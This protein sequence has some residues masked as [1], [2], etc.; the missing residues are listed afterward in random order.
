MKKTFLLFSLVL[1]VT[2]LLSKTTG[3]WEKAINAKLDQSKP[4]EAQEILKEWKLNKGESD[5][6]YWVAGGNIWIAM[7][8]EVPAVVTN[9]PLGTYKLGKGDDQAIPIQDQKTGKTVGQITDGPPQIDRPKMLKAIDCLNHGVQVAPQRLDIFTG[10]AHLYRLM[11]DLKCELKALESLS[12][13]PKPKDGHFE[14]G[15][16]KTMKKNLADYQVE[17]LNTYAREHY[18]KETTYDDNAG[19]QVAQLL[20]RKFPKYAQGYNLMAA[21]ASFKGD[22]KGSVQWLD[23]A[24]TVA[25][26]DS[27]VWANKGY[28]LNK[29]KDWT[30]ARKCYEKVLLLNN[31]PGMVQTAKEE[32]KKLK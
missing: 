25:P 11:G 19:A 15:P 7:G 29:L 16:G 21:A 23:K 24:L 9:V 18:E 17:M 32:L 31:D 8:Y 6:Q 20:I 26:A 28:G 2:P 10:R 13:D 14:D 3:D 30:G 27:L 5:P 4:L 22:W 1:A 12:S